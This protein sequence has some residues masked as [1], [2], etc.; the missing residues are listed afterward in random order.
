MMGK[1]WPRMLTVCT[2]GPGHVRLLREHIVLETGEGVVPPAEVRLKPVEGRPRIA[3]VEH[4]LI[5]GG[6][7]SGVILNLQLGGFECGS[8]LGWAD[9]VRPWE[10]RDFC[11]VTINVIYS[12]SHWNGI[13]DMLQVLFA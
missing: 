2:G 7:G 4:R 6:R 5:V 8:G 11:M 9:T 10:Y 1:L 13:V 12:H 3:H